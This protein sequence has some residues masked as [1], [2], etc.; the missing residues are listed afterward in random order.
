[1]QATT[2]A[3]RVSNCALRLFSSILCLHRIYEFHSRR[4]R[5]CQ[6]RPLVYLRVLVGFSCRRLKECR[7]GTHI[8]WLIYICIARLPYPFAKQRLIASQRSY[9]I[10][11]ALSKQPLHSAFK[12]TA[13]TTS[14]H[15]LI[16]PVTNAPN[17]VVVAFIVSAP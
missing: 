9:G 17:C 13:R 5:R 16:S 10:N 12:S 11:R 1:M 6:R 2:V 3:A 4:R 7:N 14:P 8:F 15:F